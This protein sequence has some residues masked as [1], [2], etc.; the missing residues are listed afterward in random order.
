[1]G[2]GNRAFKFIGM[3]IGMPKV[4]CVVLESIIHHVARA[5]TDTVTLL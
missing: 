1:M 2:I 4:D 3:V 5:L